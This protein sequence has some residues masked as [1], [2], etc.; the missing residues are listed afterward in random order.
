M[1]EKSVLGRNNSKT[2]REQRQASAAERKAK[3]DSMDIWAQKAQMK[4]NFEL[5]NHKQHYESR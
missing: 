5:Y 1:K 4:K 2:R 3:W